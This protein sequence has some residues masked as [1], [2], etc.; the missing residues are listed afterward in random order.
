M[1]DI[2]IFLHPGRWHLS[3]QRSGNSVTWLCVTIRTIA[4]TATA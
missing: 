3:V 2:T 4:K 1:N